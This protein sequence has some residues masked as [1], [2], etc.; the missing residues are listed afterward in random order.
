[1]GTLTVGRAVDLPHPALADQ[2]GDVVVAEPGADVEWH[3]GSP[4]SSARIRIHEGQHK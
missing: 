2:G 4:F 3:L 1:M